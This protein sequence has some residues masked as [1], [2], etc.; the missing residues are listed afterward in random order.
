MNTVLEMPL[1]TAIRGVQQMADFITEH[2]K[3][4]FSGIGVAVLFWFIGYKNNNSN[5]S[6]QSMHIGDNSAGIQ[7]GRDLN[8][9]NKKDKEYV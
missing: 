7:I 2:Y 3:W 8:E 9:K 6:K 5:K 4:I 1:E